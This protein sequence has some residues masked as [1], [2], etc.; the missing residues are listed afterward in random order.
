MSIPVDFLRR[1]GK[2]WTGGFRSFTPNQLRLVPEVVTPRVVAPVATA[3][4][5]TV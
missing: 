5:A 3:Q 4:P 2:Q 1:R